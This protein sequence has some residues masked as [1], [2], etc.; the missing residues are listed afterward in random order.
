MKAQCPIVCSNR[1][2]I[3]E[4]V[5]DAA[6]QFNPDDPEDIALKML[7]LMDFKT[8]RVL[9]KKGK[10]RAKIFSWEKC[11]QETLH[12]FRNVVTNHSSR[13]EGR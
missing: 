12:V 13:R 6:L 2:S 9:I 3:P 4:I 10:E 11:A 8:R 7:K 5:A 1:G